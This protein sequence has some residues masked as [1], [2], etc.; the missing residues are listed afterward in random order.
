MVVPLPEAMRAFAAICIA[1][2]ECEYQ[3]PHDSGAML[4]REAA[5]R[6]F[7]TAHLAQINC[8]SRY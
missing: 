6:L 8:Q 1:L 5:V 7:K 4:G 2:W 3:G